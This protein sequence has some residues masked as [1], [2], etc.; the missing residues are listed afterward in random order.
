MCKWSVAV[1]LALLMFTSAM[2]LKAITAQP[3]LANTSSPM[4]PTP[5]ANTSSP[6]PPTPWLLANTSSPMPP[7]PWANTS[8][9][10]PPT[11][12]R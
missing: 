11:P 10:M 4:P 3:V 7:T 9:P 8:S 2:G 6:M 5:W 12:W 1:A